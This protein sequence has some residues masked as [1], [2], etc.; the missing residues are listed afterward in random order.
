MR[1]FLS[2]IL[3]WLLAASMTGC[4]S[5]S[6]ADP[7]PPPGVTKN[8]VCPDPEAIQKRKLRLINPQKGKIPPRLGSKR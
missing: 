2:L 6:S 8:P 5:Q 3:L 1:C 4:G 7:N